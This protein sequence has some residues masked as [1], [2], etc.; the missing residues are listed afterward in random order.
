M[1]LPD[2]VVL[3]VNETLLDLAPL[4]PAVAGAVG[5]DGALGEWFARTL[6]GSLLANQL[7]VYRAFAEIATDALQTVAA[8]RG[9]ALDRDAA[10]TVVDGM[11]S[12]PPHPDVLP[13]LERLKA[14]GLR[15]V[16]LTNNAYDVAIDQISHSGIAGYLDTLL[17]VDE[18]RRFKPAPEVYL[19]TSMRSGA[20]LDRCLMV[21]AHDWDVRG[22]Q[23]VGMKGAFLARP[24]AIWGLPDPVPELS[25]DDLGSLADR[26]LSAEDPA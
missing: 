25:A 7:G 14:A 16:A 26:L 17:S 10:A 24:G 23:G 18:V 1:T 9:T 11:R 2:V 22:A 15:L 13:A 8:R 6:H 4:G 21:A 20:E 5:S 12:L 3:D 19:M